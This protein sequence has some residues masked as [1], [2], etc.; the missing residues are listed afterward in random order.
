MS[1]MTDNLQDVNKSQPASKRKA[2]LV[3]VASFSAA[4]ISVAALYFFY[5][6]PN[7]IEL[8]YPYTPAGAEKVTETQNS[9]YELLNSENEVDRQKAEKAVRL[10][11]EAAVQSGN[12]QYM[13]K[14]DIWRAGLLVRD[15]KTEE[16]VSLLVPYES[17][18]NDLSDK[19]KDYLFSAISWAYRQ[20]GNIDRADEYQQ[21]IKGESFDANEQ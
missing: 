8:T 5:I 10:E 9:I 7:W 19:D 12:K 4:L 17:Q 3:I 2:T 6:K 13:L 14:T 1:G 21:K 11:S 20:Q 18:L 15:Q 16:A